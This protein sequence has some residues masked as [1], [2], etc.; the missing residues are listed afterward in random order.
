V[1]TFLAIWGA[2][3]GTIP[4]I[5]VIRREFFLSRAR[6]GLKHGVQILMGEDGPNVR[7]AWLVIH[8]WNDGGQPLT[9]ERPRWQF[10]NNSL[11]NE[12]EP[13]AK[14]LTRGESFRPSSWPSASRS[15]ARDRHPRA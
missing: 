3:S 1:S 15:R 9:V 2:A 4:T 7:D 6:L 12:S 14:S 13:G 8:V 11:L 5:A 10:H